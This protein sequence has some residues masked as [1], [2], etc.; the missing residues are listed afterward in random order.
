MVG[1]LC[2]RCRGLTR[3]LARKLER[4][5]GADLEQ[6]GLHQPGRRACLAADSDSGR[7]EPSRLVVVSKWRDSPLYVRSELQAEVRSDQEIARRGQHGGM[8]QHGI[9]IGGEE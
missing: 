7:E 2:L 6:Q 5:R 8:E 9:E 4:A 1:T 3:N